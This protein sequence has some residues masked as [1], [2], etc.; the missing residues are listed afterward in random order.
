[1]AGAQLAQAIALNFE[2]K[3]PTL[4]V[5]KDT[6]TLGIFQGLQRAINAANTRIGTGA[7]PIRADGDIG[8]KTLTAAQAAASRAGAS[9][10][11]AQFVLSVGQL[12]A[13][14]VRAAEVFSA[15]GR[16]PT[17]F[18]PSPAA[19]PPSATPVPAKAE[20]LAP[21]EKPRA[22]GGIHWGWW[23]G[24]LALLGLA[25]F[26]TWRH[27]SKGKTAFAGGDGYDSYDYEEAAG[28]FIDV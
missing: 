17:D 8:S 26:F 11:L 16:V 1:M 19:R 12:A 27:F 5:P 21:P 20:P 7:E 15:I 23:V 10:Q 13:N 9:S 3:T 6:A 28:D 24:G 18:T 25:G 22:V 4:A 2:M 14:A